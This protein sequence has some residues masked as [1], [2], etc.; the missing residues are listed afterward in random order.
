MEYGLNSGDFSR[1]RK[2]PVEHV[3]GLVLHMAAHRNG[4]GYDITAQNYFS[5]LREYLG[6]EGIEP[7]TRQ[8]ISQ[9]RAKLDWEAFRHLL[10]EANQDRELASRGFCY[11][12]HVTRAI[13]GT[14][15]TLPL[16]SDLLDF[17]G[18]PGTAWCF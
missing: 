13:D 7:V 3:V 1:E 6:D 5:E 10:H 16:S 18:A 12:G 4:D 9:A 2:L 8:G 14:Q 15:L 11:R 17:F